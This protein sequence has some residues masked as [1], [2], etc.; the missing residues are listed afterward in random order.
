M[1]GDPRQPAKLQKRKSRERQELAMSGGLN[2]PPATSSQV[3]SNNNSSN[4]DK[5]KSKFRL[6]N[7]FHSKE[8]EKE[9]EKSNTKEDNNTKR[10]TLDTNGD[11]AYGSSEP[12]TSANPSF[13]SNANPSFTSNPRPVSG[14][15]WHPPPS[16]TNL[17][18]TAAPPPGQNNL[19]PPAHSL[20]NRSSQENITKESYRDAGTGTV[21]TTTTTVRTPS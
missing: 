5:K 13:S 1:E 8:K 9:K 4:E 14:E 19:A 6:S 18:Q 17:P 16:S 2:G 10:N 11:S 21:V 20:Q 7:P 15:Q 3:N 12:D